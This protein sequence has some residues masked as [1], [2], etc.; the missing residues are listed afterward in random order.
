MRVRCIENKY[1][2]LPASSVHYSPHC[3]DDATLSL[4]VNKEYVVYAIWG[5]GNE[6]LFSSEYSRYPS[7]FPSILF[8]VVDDRL[9]T[10]W[11]FK[12]YSDTNFLIAFPEWISG[13]SFNE[14]VVDGE[15]YT[16]EI[17]QRYRAEIYWDSVS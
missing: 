15:P 5:S 1:R 8:E 16:Q 12:P 3:D 6:I 7:W 4:Q 13:E 11:R 14:D 10:C 17:W 2:S 9:P